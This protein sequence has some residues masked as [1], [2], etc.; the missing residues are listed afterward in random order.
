MLTSSAARILEE[1]EDDQAQI[2]K[3]KRAIT[4][5]EMTNSRKSWEQL[6]PSWIYQHK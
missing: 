2:N 5:A 1:H 4:F 6:L 3:K